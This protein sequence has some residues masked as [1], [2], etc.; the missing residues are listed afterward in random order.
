MTDPIPIRRIR[1]NG[2]VDLIGHYAHTERRL[3]LAAPGFPLSGVG[4]H[5]VDGDLP[6]VLEEMAP[7]GFLARRFSGW[8]AGL[9]LPVDRNLWTA[10]HVLSAV[11][12]CGH[13]LPGNLVVG[14]G[15]WER[16]RRIFQAGTKPGPDPIAARDHYLHF[17]DDILSEPGGSSVGG[18]RPK[19]SLRL[20][21]GGAALV[22]F[23]PPLDTPAGVRWADLL[24]M[25]Q[26][27]SATLQSAGIPAVTSR[28]VELGSRGYLEVDRYD[29]LAGGG[30]RGAVTFYWLGL[31]LFSE[32]GPQA[33]PTITR[34]LASTGV[35]T[36][37]EAELVVR[38]H[39]FSASVG[40][41]DAHTGNY[42]LLI[43]D[44]GHTS[45]APFFDIS[46]MIFAPRHDE[47]PDHRIAPR[48]PAPT[49]DNA[50]LVHE[51]H[52]RARADAGVSRAFLDSWSRRLTL[53][54]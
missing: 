25:E 41:T 14:E 32:A 22:K 5:E 18:E 45:L 27:T 21:D 42:G 7:S 48:F 49:A 24:R 4:N 15:S 39:Q 20:A 8:Y 23:T 31:A 30:R 51:L 38:I 12:E 36:P 1:T 44:E 52:D 29:R 17:V 6:W 9:T 33:V 34:S 13:D 46:P 40:N 2:A 43:D 50:P 54:R 26:H 3:E 28:Y 19:F 53:A 37:E 16:Y 47:L 10:Q 35:L 11:T